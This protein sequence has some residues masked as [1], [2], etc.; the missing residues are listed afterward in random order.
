M[1]GSHGANAAKDGSM[2]IRMSSLYPALTLTHDLFDPHPHP[3]PLQS[4]NHAIIGKETPQ[5][6]KPLQFISH[7]GKGGGGG[8]RATPSQHTALHSQASN[9]TL[10]RGCLG[11]E[12]RRGGAGGSPELWA[13]SGQPVEHRDCRPRRLLRQPH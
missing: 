5:S 2:Q 12:G 1:R 4:P 6:D 9:G 3:P 10:E 11:E 7:G 13:S 8:N